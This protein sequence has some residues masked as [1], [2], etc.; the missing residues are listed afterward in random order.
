[1]KSNDIIK[2]YENS[3]FVQFCATGEL[4]IMNTVRLDHGVT[5][6]RKG[7]G[8]EARYHDSKGESILIDLF[9]NDSLSAMAFQRL[10]K[11]VARYARYRRLASFCKGVVK[12]GV[13]PLVLCLLALAVNM[14][15]TRSLGGNSTGAAPMVPLPS[16]L[17]A[18]QQPGM[19]APRTAVTS[20]AEL[21]KAMADGVNAGKFS[22]Q[23]SK[24]NKGTFYVFSDPSCSHC[25]ELEP[26]LT[27]LAKDYTIHIF[28]VSV[29]G[30]DVSLQ[31]VT[32]LL[33]AKPDARATLWKK[34][35]GDDDLQLTPC[36][37]GLSAVT[38][39]NQIFR[40]MR[41]AGTPTIINAAGVELPDSI[42]NTADAIGQWMMTTAS[43][44]K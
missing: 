14:A 3:L 21:A 17:G 11:A 16:N 8:I 5:F 29:I 15:A 43:D 1:M 32:K 42:Q 22:V 39:N 41:F 19:P 12:W 36:D 13:A 10:Q 28:P 31:R 27:R 18:L 6:N 23:L 7:N 44:K 20:P 40:V 38:A 37:E 4:K 35:V 2:P 24:G 34:I 25:R 33:C 30:G 9:A 26:E